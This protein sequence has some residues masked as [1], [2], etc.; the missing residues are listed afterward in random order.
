MK[1][2]VLIA[3]VLASFV[4][5]E[6]VVAGEVTGTISS[7]IVRQSD[8]LTYFYMNGTPTGK[9]A[10]AGRPYWMIKDENSEVGK[11]LYALLLTAKTTDAT[12]RVVGL[13]TCTRWS[14]GEDVDWIQLQ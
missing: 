14:D 3:L 1:N 11:K 10:C 13:N 9:P 8:G 12:V 2:L 4:A 6:A 5:S 7:V